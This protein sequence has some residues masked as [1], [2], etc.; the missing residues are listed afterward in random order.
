MFNFFNY[1]KKI[2][3]KNETFVENKN[4]S[5]NIDE[6]PYFLE[7]IED[8]NLKDDL[9]EGENIILILKKKYKNN[10]NNFRLK[11]IFTNLFNINNIVKSFV[12]KQIDIKDYINIYFNLNNFD[13]NFVINTIQKIKIILDYIIE[14]EKLIKLYNLNIE[15]DIEYLKLNKT[16][17]NEHIIFK[18]PNLLLTYEDDICNIFDN[19]TY[20]HN[21]FNNII[22]N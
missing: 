5:Y 17:I 9:L 4:F 1:F 10:I 3:Y 22:K 14:K 2:F 7:I 15:K 16:I 20:I 6:I 18:I 8:N 21:Y 13:H 11:N 12:E 19:L